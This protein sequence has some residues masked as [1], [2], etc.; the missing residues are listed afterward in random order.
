M[1][2]TH[3]FSIEFLPRQMLFG[4]HLP[5]KSMISPENEVYNMY[6]IE[7]GFIF[8]KFRYMVIIPQ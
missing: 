7:L 4:I 2:K 6:G 5:N 1:N 8:F 3:E